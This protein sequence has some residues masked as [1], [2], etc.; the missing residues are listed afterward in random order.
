M[1]LRAE[2]LMLGLILALGAPGLAG[3][4][5]A[6]SARQLD[7][8]AIRISGD[9]R[10]R[11]DTVGDGRF[12]STASF[13]LVDAE[14][15]AADGAY[16]TL[17]GELIDASGGQ[18][19]VIGRL[20]PQSLWVPPHESRTFALV[21]DQQ[22]ARPAS[23]A[24]RIRV[25]G[26][27]IPDDPPRAHIADL[28]SFDDRGKVVV[29]AYLVNEA[30]RVGQVMVIGAFHDARGQPMTRPF[31]VIAVGA[32]DRRVVQFVGPEGS[33]RGTIFVGDIIY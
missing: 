6:R 19:V 15:A 12:A 28:H 10:L 30:D 9:A 32:H 31:Q 27:G 29:Q 7:L 11:T 2:I 25:F 14:N 33:T 22:T 21:D 26:A 16:V 20:K 4:G 8:D 5:R 1:M 24:A 18:G 13:V 23:T 3:C 17:G